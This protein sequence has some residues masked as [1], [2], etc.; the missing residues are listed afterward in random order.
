MS[1]FGSRS[2]RLVLDNKPTL[3][4]S[5]V[6]LALRMSDARMWKWIS[7]HLSFLGRIKH[8]T[9]Q[10]FLLEAFQKVTIVK[11]AWEESDVP[12]LQPHYCH[13]WTVRSLNFLSLFP[14]QHTGSYDSWMACLLLWCRRS[15]KTSI[16]SITPAMS[17]SLQARF[18]CSQTWNTWTS[19]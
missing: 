10:N 7:Y 1:Y 16:Y 13:L 15:N 11:G 19:S 12:G 9:R 3:S 5:A 14:Q 17:W 6:Y 18:S 2:Q 8:K 4:L